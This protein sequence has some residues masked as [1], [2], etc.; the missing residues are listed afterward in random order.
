MVI[1]KFQAD[2]YFVLLSDIHS[3]IHFIELLF[4]QWHFSC[5]FHFGVRSNWPPAMRYANDTDFCYFIRFH[6]INVQCSMNHVYLGECFFYFIRILINWFIG[7]WSM[8]MVETIH[9]LAVYYFEM[10]HLQLERKLN[11]QIERIKN[12]GWDKSEACCL[13]RAM[14][15]IDWSATELLWHLI[16]IRKIN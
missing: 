3:L 16:H 10:Q 14:K 9:E 1:L 12:V 6:S 5:S 11:D 2:L 4:S 8:W 7:G 15:V 13:N